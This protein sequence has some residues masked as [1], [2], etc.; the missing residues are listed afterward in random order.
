MKKA[1]NY[2]ENLRRKQKPTKQQRCDGK[3][4]VEIVTGEVSGRMGTRTK[5]TTVGSNKHPK[6]EAKHNPE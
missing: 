5:T 4:R 6:D 2:R 3:Q 1:T